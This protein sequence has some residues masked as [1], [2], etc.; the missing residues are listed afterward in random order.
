MLREETRRRCR[1]SRY[2]NVPEVI[3][4]P[5]NETEHYRI[6]ITSY[7]VLGIKVHDV[8]Q[9]SPEMCGKSQVF[10]LIRG[11]KYDRKDHGE[12]NHSAQY[13]NCLNSGRF[14]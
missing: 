4:K 7:G 13:F 9:K 6:A 5:E 11:P 10:R 12:W 14:Y 2:K 8:A 1:E 3:I